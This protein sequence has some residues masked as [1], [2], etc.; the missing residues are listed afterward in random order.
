MDLLFLEIVNE[1]VFRPMIGQFGIILFLS[2]AKN[3]TNN[4]PGCHKLTNKIAI[5]ICRHVPSADIIHIEKLYTL[6]MLLIMAFISQVIE[7]STCK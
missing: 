1:T 6:T 7:P 4:N 5:I 2:L 3:F